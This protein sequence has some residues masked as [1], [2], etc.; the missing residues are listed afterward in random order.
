MLAWEHN[1]DPLPFSVGGVGNWLSLVIHHSWGFFLTFSH[2]S[3]LSRVLV[4]GSGYGP[5]S[6]RWRCWCKPQL[7]ESHRWC[8]IPPYTGDAFSTVFL[9]IP[10]NPV[11]PVPIPFSRK[12]NQP[13]LILYP[14]GDGTGMANLQGIR[15]NAEWICNLCIE[16]WAYAYFQVNRTY[17]HGVLAMLQIWQK[18][19]VHW[20]VCNTLLHAANRPTKV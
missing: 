13:V 14:A 19:V 3:F 7:Q 1:T 15:I 16:L 17:L 20:S 18:S 10:P 5:F 6:G 9:L 4:E 12:P 11:D 8:G 2:S